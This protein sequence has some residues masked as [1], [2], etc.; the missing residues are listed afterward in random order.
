[1]AGVPETP[2]NYD[3]RSQERE[4][5]VVGQVPAPSQA[6]QTSHRTPPCTVYLLSQCE[7]Y[8][9]LKRYFGGTL[10]DGS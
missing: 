8:D 9:L 4:L 2:G 6:L 1:M 5:H 10:D 7:K 3:E